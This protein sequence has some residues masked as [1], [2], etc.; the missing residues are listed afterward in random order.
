MRG[1][2]ELE[3][4]E[5]LKQLNEIRKVA[6]ECITEIGIAEI[7]K[8]LPVLTGNETEAE[9]QEKVTQQAK[10]NISAMLDSALEQHP[11]ATE[12]LLETLL[13]YDPGEKHLTGA[14][15]VSRALRELM[16]DAVI[17]FLLSA[18]K[19]GITGLDA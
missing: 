12:R 11:E 19:L 6:D 5:F 13:V 10:K 1:I 7:R 16:D 14:K 4:R 18:A 9:K 8:R 2:T 3:T 17:D 15:F